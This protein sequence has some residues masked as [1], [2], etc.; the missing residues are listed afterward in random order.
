[1]ISKH[2]FITLSYSEY[3]MSEQQ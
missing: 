2:S 3:Y 1:M